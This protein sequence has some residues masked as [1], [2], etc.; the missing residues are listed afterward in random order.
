MFKEVPDHSNDHFIGDRPACEEP[1]ESVP[2]EARKL[3]L[4]YAILGTAFRKQREERK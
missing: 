1:E 3:L 4:T 2:S